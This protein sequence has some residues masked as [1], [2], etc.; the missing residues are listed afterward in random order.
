MMREEISPLIEEKEKELE[1]LEKKLRYNSI[2][3]NREYAFCLYPEPMLRE[4][5]TWL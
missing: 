3:T 2:I 1:D 5:F 4:L